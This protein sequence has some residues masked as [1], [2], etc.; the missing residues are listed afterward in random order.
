MG[1]VTDVASSVLFLVALASAEVP[2]GNAFFGYSYYN[3]TTLF[4]PLFGRATTT[5]GRI[6]PSI[7][8]SQP[9][10]AWVPVQQSGW[11]ESSARGCFLG[12]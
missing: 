4:S 8:A 9:L 11:A 12:Q 3:S 1:K 7:D 6:L 10:V 2:S 5:N